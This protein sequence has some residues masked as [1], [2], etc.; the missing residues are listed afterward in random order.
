MTLKTLVKISPLKDQDKT[1]VM[2]KIDKGELSADQIFQITKMCW[3]LIFKM[4]DIEWSLTVEK[5]MMEEAEGTKKY[6]PR[7][8]SEEQAKLLY[9]FT[10]Q[11][12]SEESKEAMD[13]IKD[14]LAN[15]TNNTVVVPAAEK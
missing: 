7:D 15:R 6:T 3:D 10:L 11:L 12:E 2:D 8:Y 5:M 14:K 1:N 4:Y 13:D 9:K